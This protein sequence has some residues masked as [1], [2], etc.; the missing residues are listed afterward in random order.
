MVA[1]RGQLL[2]RR[3]SPQ[4]LQAL[5]GRLQAPLGR[6]L[7]EPREDRVQRLL[8]KNVQDFNSVGGAEEKKVTLGLTFSVSQ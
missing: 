5:L 8:G 3:Q 2:V 6:R 4:V 1:Q 7:D